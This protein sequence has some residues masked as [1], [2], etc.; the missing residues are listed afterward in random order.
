MKKLAFF[1]GELLYWI[2]QK[3][4]QENR[5]EEQRKTFLSVKIIFKENWERYKGL[6]NTREVEK[7]EVEKMLSC[8]GMER[9]CFVYYCKNCN[10]EVIVPFGCNSRICSCCGKRHADR[11]ADK[12]ANKIEGGITYRH[13]TFSIPSVLWPY[14][15]ENRMLMKIMMDIAYKTSQRIFS[16]SVNNH[17]TPGIIAVL[18]PFIGDLSFSPHVHCIATEGGFS[19]DGKF[20]PLK[21]YVNYSSFHLKWQ[22]DI[23]SAFRKYI[24]KEVIDLCF[25]QY[26]KGFCA[27]LKPE[28]IRAGKG[29]ICY[30]GR[31][32]RHPSIANSRIVAYNGE[33]VK[34]IYK[35]KEEKEVF[36][37]MLVDD[38]ISAIISH[39]PERNFKMIRYYGI[40]SRKRMRNTRERFKQLSITQKLLFKPTENKIFICPYC[41]EKMEFI[42]YCKKPPPKSKNNLDYW[43]SA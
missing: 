40:Y 30:I 6:Y 15:K 28:K 12:L 2:I 11:W 3:T 22:Y 21:P 20:I 29:L 33:A 24:P 8:K 25:R 27:Y 41:Y 32:I 13:L 16:S 7:T 31:Y 10:R 36:K 17:I 39:I 23:L 18:H 1:K 42:M 5:G 37:I 19:D 34:F 43:I 26:P 4:I 9:G 35:D 38:F 14:V